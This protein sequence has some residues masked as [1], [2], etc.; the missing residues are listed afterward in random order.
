MKKFR[1]R[2]KVLRHVISG[3]ALVTMLSVGSGM[4]AQAQSSA[5]VSAASNEAAIFV[6][7]SAWLVGPISVQ[8]PKDD[9]DM[10][11]VMMNRFDNGF[12]VRISGTDKQ[13]LAIAVDFRK[14][15]F[16]IGEEYDI[17]LRVGDYEQALSAQAYD[18]STLVMNTNHS[19]DLFQQIRTAKSMI[20][21]FGSTDLP[22]SLLSAKEGLDRL[23]AC[24]STPQSRSADRVKAIESNLREDIKK[25][26]ASAVKAGG[27]YLEPIDAVRDDGA[28]VSDVDK[29][30]V[31]AKVGAPD[32]DNI[33][34]ADKEPRNQASEDDA[35]GVESAAVMLDNFLGGSAKSSPPKK[36]KDSSASKET[37]PSFPAEAV[38][39]P[40]IQNQNTPIGGSA[41]MKWEAQQGGSLKD[42]LNIW[43]SHQKVG[44]LWALKG[45]YYLPRRFNYQGTFEDAVRAV[46]SEFSNEQYPLHAKLYS[47][48]RT[49]QA[50][51]LIGYEDGE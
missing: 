39:R 15:L 10:P 30:N 32:N 40:V 8:K 50:Y 31:A 27:G 35:E 51:L 33:A 4:N 2:Q 20:V 23:A 25:H 22:F 9:K 28:A 38:P 5:P 24:Y 12:G 14:T 37:K 11:C 43:T 29:T 26:S 48:P 49:G 46:V 3:V 17:K 19:V 36:T 13:V 7:T 47:D 34:T 44:L 45:N 16:D 6:P 1:K 41:F 18:G 42:V 21:T